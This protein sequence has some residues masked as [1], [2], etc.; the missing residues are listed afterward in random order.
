M[1]LISA[2]EHLIFYIILVVLLLVY[3]KNQVRC[4]YVA[5]GYLGLFSF[6]F[7]ER[8]CST[9]L[10]CLLASTQPR[11]SPPKFGLPACPGPPPTHPPF[12]VEERAKQTSRTRSR[13][14][15][16]VLSSSCRSSMTWAENKE[17]SRCTNMKY[18]RNIESFRNIDISEIF[19]LFEILL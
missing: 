16:K 1:L 4:T 15:V 9:L 11:T 3:W 10:A 8:D 19:N 18:H 12:W 17:S 2:T 7:H 6:L 5:R 13:S 14:Y